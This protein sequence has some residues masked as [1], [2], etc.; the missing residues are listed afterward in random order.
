M[1]ELRH[2]GPSTLEL[3]FA[4]DTYNAAV[5]LARAAR[6]MGL[7]VDVGFVTGIGDDTYSRRMRQAWQQ[8][9]I[10]DKSV[11]VPGT[12]PGLYIVQTDQSGER[13]FS[14][15]RSGSAAAR[16]FARTDWL[17]AL[18]ADVV[19][20]SGIALQLMSA[21][22][23]GQLIR[24]LGLIRS[25]GTLVAFDTNYRPE[26]WAAVE[27]AL[28]AISDTAATA[29]IVFATLADEQQLIPGTDG[30][31]CGHRYLQIGAAEVIV[32]VGADGIYLFTAAGGSHI[33]A[34]PVAQV[35]DTTA[36]GDSLA[37][38]YLA[39]RLAGHEPYR[40]AQAAVQVA[41]TVIGRPGAIVQVS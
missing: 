40:A 17:A 28:E 14:Y 24:H 31:T 7:P 38:T 1:L 2:T 12:L 33:P 22:V 35:V 26:G 15:W 3:G 8:E 18:D 21:D 30:A 37:G 23:R 27:E 25:Q 20:L 29:D 9:D 34:A 10:T 16:L 5:Y 13:S 41:A 32:K 4:G 11:I 39:A 36:A 6:D 19:Y